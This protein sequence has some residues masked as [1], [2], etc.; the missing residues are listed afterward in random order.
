M[1][2]PVA[3]NF[4]FNIIINAIYPVMTQSFGIG[5]TF[6]AFGIVCIISVIFILLFVPETKGLSLEKIEENWKNG[7]VP[8]K[9]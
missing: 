5:K 6:S 8:S 2:F 9:F 1:T 7:V 4:I 3:A